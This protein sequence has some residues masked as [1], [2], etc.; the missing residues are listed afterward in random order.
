[1]AKAKDPAKDGRKNNGGPRPKTRDD[2]KRGQRPEGTPHQPAF[3]PSDVQ[4]QRVA[5][6]ARSCTDDEIAAMEEISKSTL[7]RHYG[8]A[9][10]ISRASTTAMIGSKLISAALSGCKARQM[11][12]LRT[13]GG[14]KTGHEIAG[15]GG[16]PIRTFDLS[17][18]SPEEIA[19]MMPLLDQLI[20]QGG[21]EFNP[22]DAAED[23]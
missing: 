5:T 20:E 18:Y 22:E 14:W 15:P 13:K 11:F 19:K 9:M 17:G 12:Y 16:G 7:Q 21:G 8:E 3:E 4:R 10:R 23:G 2:D 1:M 6:L